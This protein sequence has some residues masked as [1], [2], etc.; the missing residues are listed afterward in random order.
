MSLGKA[1]AAPA[2]AERPEWTRIP[3]KRDWW[4]HRDGVYKT[5]APS[6]QVPDP[7]VKPPPEPPATDITLFVKGLAVRNQGAPT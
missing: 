1:I 2:P 4:I 6:G 3:G 5:F 7:I